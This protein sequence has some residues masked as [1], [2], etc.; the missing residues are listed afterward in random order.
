MP[1]HSVHACLLR[2]LTLK[3]T[4]EI[5]GPILEYSICESPCQHSTCSLPMSLLGAGG[6]HDMP[7]SPCMPAACAHPQ[8]APLRF[9]DPSTNTA[10][11]QVRVS[12]PHA[13]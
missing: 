10:F 1:C 8:E 9:R 5:Q 4:Y 2:F 7:I 6:E 13:V 11:V 3:R 12:T